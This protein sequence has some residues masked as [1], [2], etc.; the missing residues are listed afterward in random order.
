MNL[1]QLKAIKTIPAVR[2]DSSF[3][4]DLKK[5]ILLIT[6]AKEQG[7]SLSK[8]E[9][10]MTTLEYTFINPSKETEVRMYM[11]NPAKFNIK[12]INRE[13]I[14]YKIIDD[15]VIAKVKGDILHYTI[16]K[17]KLAKE[18]TGNLVFRS[19]DY[20]FEYTTSDNTTERIYGESLKSSMLS[21]NTITPCP[22]ITY[23]INREV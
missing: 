20:Y 23:T 22:N 18:L 7:Y 15:M 10:T 5:E 19:K 4:S 6:Q 17:S 8:K 12:D 21:G 1:K 13:V 2:T 14:S 11:P 3:L 9:E 16:T